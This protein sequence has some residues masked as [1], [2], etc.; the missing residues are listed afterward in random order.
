M[1]WSSPISVVL[2]A[3][4]TWLVVWAVVSSLGLGRGTGWRRLVWPI[5]IL[6]FNVYLQLG[7]VGSIYVPLGALVYAWASRPYRRAMKR[8]AA[9]AVQ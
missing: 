9:D 5:V 3:L 4:A 8:N 7:D 1:T 6:G 2:F